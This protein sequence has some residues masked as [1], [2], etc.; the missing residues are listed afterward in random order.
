VALKRRTFTESGKM[1][2]ECLI[3]LRDEQ[4]TEVYYQRD[5]GTTLIERRLATHG[6]KVRLRKYRNEERS[7]PSYPT[8][9]MRDLHNALA[10]AIHV[11]S[12]KCPREFKRREWR[13]NLD[14]AKKL[15][16]QRGE[17][18]GFGE[19]ASAIIPKRR[20]V[21]KPRWRKLVCR[22]CRTPLLFGYVLD[23]EKIT[24]AK[25]FCSDTCRVSAA[26]KLKPHSHKSR[27]R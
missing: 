5:Q 21:E 25:E 7:L 17:P 20:N 13:G 11:E 19:I 12:D 27:A 4:S 14:L 16:T 8:T 18:S 23:G 15:W 3:E 24:R 22:S 2:A 10:V 6:E 26:R 9:R 1:F